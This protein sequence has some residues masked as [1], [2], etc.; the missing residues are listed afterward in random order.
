MFIGLKIPLG[1]ELCKN[2]YFGG[3]YI[4]INWIELKK[5]QL[6]FTY[7]MSASHPMIKNTFQTTPLKN[8]HT[9]K[10]FELKETIKSVSSARK[11]HFLIIL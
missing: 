9:I 2:R 7:E 11:I 8:Y 3:P 6:N 1:T 4:V 5:L 10:I